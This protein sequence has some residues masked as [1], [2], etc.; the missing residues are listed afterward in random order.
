MPELRAM[1]MD[2]ISIEVRIDCLVTLSNFGENKVSSL[3]ACLDQSDHTIQQQ[4][5]VALFAS[6]DLDGLLT[7]GKKLSSWINSSE[8]KERILAA[9]TIGK[10]S[11]QGFH[12]SILRLLNDHSIAV[13]NAAIKSASKEKNLKL[14][15]LLIEKQYAH[16]CFRSSRLAGC[17]WRRYNQLFAVSE[18]LEKYGY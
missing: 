5:I 7:A 9:E 8:E 12:H 11:G 6:G 2:D 18:Q 10:F 1:L 4:A 16:C 3:A 17:L 13:Q 15:P 14:V